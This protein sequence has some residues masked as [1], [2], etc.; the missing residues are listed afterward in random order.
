MIPTVP[1]CRRSGGGTVYKTHKASNTAFRTF[2]QVQPHMIQ[3]EAPALA[4]RRLA[5]VAWQILRHVLPSRPLDRDRYQGPV[6]A[7]AR[8]TSQRTC[9]AAYGDNHADF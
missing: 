8:D 9:K 5:V 4:A 2:G 3:E 7:N 6:H 1:A